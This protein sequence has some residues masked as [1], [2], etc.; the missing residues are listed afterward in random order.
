MQDP[1]DNFLDIWASFSIDDNDDDGLV[2]NWQIYL[3]EQY[4]EKE[5]RMSE[6]LQVCN[7]NQYRNETIYHAN[8]FW[9]M[10]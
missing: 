5:R 6:M 7:L 10:N 3:L 8:D 9:K 4:K 2:K 1:S